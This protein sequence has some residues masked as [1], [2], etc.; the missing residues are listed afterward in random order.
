M[1]GEGTKLSKC[2]VLYRMTKSLSS[3]F[4]GETAHDREDGASVEEEGRQPTLLTVERALRLLRSIVFKQSLSVREAARVTG[5]S[6]S[7]AFRLLRTL[8]EE[9]F[10][11]RDMDT[12]RFQPGP[13]LRRM[14]AHILGTNDVRRAAAEPMSRLAELWQENITLCLRTANNQR[15]YFDRIAAPRPVQCVLPLGHTAPLHVGSSGRAMLAYMTPEEIDRAL[16]GPLLAFTSA[17]LTD[18]AAVREDLARVCARG[19]AVSFGEGVDAEMVGVSAPVFDARGVVIASIL[20]SIP[21]SRVSDREDLTRVGVSMRE[22]ADEISLRMG[23]AP[24]SRQP[25]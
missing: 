17:T 6:S 20:V 12:T 3:S 1:S 21:A 4:N 18:P 13:E 16:S 15:L 8:E 10:I 14:V 7:S 22:A 19:Y 23:W 2:G 25:T 24:G 5:T 9:G 11:E